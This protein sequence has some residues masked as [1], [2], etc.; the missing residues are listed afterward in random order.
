[1]SREMDIEPMY[2]IQLRTLLDVPVLA[3]EQLIGCI[4]KRPAWIVCNTNP[5]W[6]PDDG[7]WV[8]VHLD[9]DGRGFFFDS[10]GRDA[11]WF[12]FDQFMMDNCS[13]WMYNDKR[14]QSFASNACGH[15][16]AAFCVF[17]MNGMSYADHMSLF[18]DN[19]DVNDYIVVKW[20]DLWNRFQ[21]TYNNKS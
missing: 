4:Q 3:A 12:G 13:E 15:H 20:L 18:S 11:V 17:T 19:V 5:S 16:V 6:K 7:H 21:C 8:A 2:N 14:L 9:S 10:F 1:M